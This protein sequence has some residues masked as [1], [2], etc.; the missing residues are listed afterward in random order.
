VGARQKFTF[1][2]AP[3][4]GIGV[5]GNFTREHTLVHLNTPGYDKSS[6]I[7]N[8]PDWL[9]NVEVFY[10]KHGLSVGFLY[11]YSGNYVSQY[12]QLGLGSN[13][14]DLWVRPTRRLDMHAGYAFEN[15][16]K[17]DLSIANLLR[18][19]SYWSHIGK[20]SLTISDIVDS[21]MTGFLNVTYKF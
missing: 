15:G 3:F 14:D 8:A 19:Y 4:D 20:N 13:W 7:Q 17:V 1:L 11:N 9:A 16:V 2:P 5:S 18:G 6:P 12:D 21:G 10:E